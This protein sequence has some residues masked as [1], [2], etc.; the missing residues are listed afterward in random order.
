M[1]VIAKIL[2]L[3]LIIIFLTHLSAIASEKESFTATP[4]NYKGKQWRIGYYQ[5]GNYLIN[6][7]LLQR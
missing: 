4:D 7:Y 2:A 1:K 3:S 5:G 6:R